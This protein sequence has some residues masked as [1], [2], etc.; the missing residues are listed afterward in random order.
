MSV[1]RESRF[2]CL[3]CGT[4]SYHEWVNLEVSARTEYFSQVMYSDAADRFYIDS[5]G[6]RAED[7]DV[8]I[9]VWSSSTCAACLASTVWRDDEVV[10]PRSSPIPP[11][12]ADM[13]TDAATLYEEARQVF[14]HSRRA[15]A[16]LARATLELLLR[17]HTQDQ[18]TRLDGLIANLHGQVQESL[19]KF[20][21]A[22]RVVGNDVL[23]GGVDEG[24]VVVYLD[25]ESDEVAEP[26]FA[27][28]NSLVEQLI[29]QPRKADE[30]YMRL[31]EGKRA[32]A[33][34]K[35]AAADG[36]SG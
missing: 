29:T 17:E 5:D 4:F 3:R 26:L 35:A 12:H 13:P 7:R 1:V 20:L 36:R 31:P 28:I 18:D 6:L 33:E 16:A 11:A 8:M 9:G 34:R 19:W 25:G 27:A 24:L 23:H 32:E 30:L 22:I 21:T 10:Y 2:S 14:P 15:S